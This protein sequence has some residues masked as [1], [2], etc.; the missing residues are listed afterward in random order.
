MILQKYAVQILA[1]SLSAVLI[2]AVGCGGGSVAPTPTSN[3]QAPASSSDPSTSSASNNTSGTS[4]SGSGSSSGTGT[5]GTGNLAQSVGLLYVDLNDGY[6]LWTNS[7][8]T[9]HGAIAGFSVAADG[10]LQATPGSPYSGPAEYLAA[11]SSAVSLY[12]ASG[13]TLDV[14][15]INPDGSLTTTTT[16][17]SEPLSP[18][19]GIYADLSFNPVSQFLYATANHGAGDGFLEIYQGGADGLLNPAGSQSIGVAMSHPS[20]TPDGSRAYQ[21]FCY[22]LDGEIFGYTSSSSGQLTR[23][24]TN[25]QVAIFGSQ[26]PACPVALSISQ[27][28]SRI[29][30]QLNAVIGNTAALALYVVN[31]DGTLSLQGPPLYTS[32]QGSDVAWNASGKY[33]AVA[34]KDGLWLYSV[35]PGLEPVSV[36]TPISIVGTAL[37]AGPM[38]HVAFN[39]TG[40]LLFATS[41]S[42][43]MLYVFAFNSTSG[44]ATP[45][46]ASP[47]G[48]NAPYTLALVE[49]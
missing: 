18:S 37:A 38:D 39:K 10:S 32:A 11:N 22:H 8:S 12:A 14:N 35:V 28:G 6:S 46:P 15:R 33:V 25:A 19:I 45:A 41:S 34:A 31:A 24:Q 43:Q 29:V 47:H 27:D 49:P 48:M 7:G 5:S 42:N 17:N 9:G 3:I 16:L 4:S 30:T 23:F 2:F 36:G 13:S 20:F 1:F 26:T 21:P 44:T 40:T